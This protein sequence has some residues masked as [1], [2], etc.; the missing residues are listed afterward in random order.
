M[1]EHD[2]HRQNQRQKL[3]KTARSRLYPSITNHSYLVLRR[4]RQI[5]SDWIEDLPVSNL[6]VLDIGGRYQPYRPLLGERVSRYYAIDVVPTPFVD[7]R[8]SGQQ[9][10]F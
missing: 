3:L 2:L 4:R 7:V 10:P 5:L 9:L 6:H 1:G 8:G